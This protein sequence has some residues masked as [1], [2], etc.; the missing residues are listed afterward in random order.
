MEVEINFFLQNPKFLEGFREI[1]EELLLFSE[2]TDKMYSLT[3]YLQAILRKNPD[4]K[5]IQTQMN[6]LNEIR[7]AEG[8]EVAEINRGMKFLGF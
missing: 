4:L 1:H 7:L 3:K 5:V 6:N 2:K 8:L